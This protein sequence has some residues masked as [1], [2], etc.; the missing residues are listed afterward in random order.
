MTAARSRSHPPDTILT[1]TLRGDGLMKRRRLLTAAIALV[2]RPAVA[3]AQGAT[4]YRVAVVELAKETPEHKTQQQALRSAM[5]EL[6]YIE[7]SNVTIDWRYA[8]NDLGRLRALVSEV[9]ALGPDVL[10]GFETVAQA[11]RERTTSIPIVLTGGFD[12]VR[13]G[14][15]RSLR[16]PGFNVTGSTQIMDELTAKHFEILR[17]IIPRLSRVGQ[18]VETTSPGC[19]IIEEHAR[20]SAQELGIAFI[21]YT[22]GNQNEI[23]RAFAR[24]EKERP[25]AL[26][27]CPSPVLFSLR[28]VLFQ[29]AVR[30][31]IPFTSYVV[32]NL[33]LGVLFAYAA[34]IDEGYRRAALYVDKIL[35][36]AKAGELPIEQPSRVQF[37]I[38]LRTAKAFGLDIPR[39][40]LLRADRVIE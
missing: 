17:Q 23:E 40:L 12:P 18:L 38:N 27:P 2:T 25:D 7:G 10:L 39:P 37:V 19:R 9:I 28:E 24:M 26:L 8:D 29:N 11:M 15:A 14:L 34:T 5:R 36:G 16:H 22:V 1:V 21:P 13:A 32:T 20:R 30:L 31:H 33:P 4:K 35:R 6:G 3:A